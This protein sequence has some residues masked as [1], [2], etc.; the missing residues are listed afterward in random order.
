MFRESRA[1]DGSLSYLSILDGVKLIE[2]MDVYDVEFNRMMKIKEV[3][4]SHDQEVTL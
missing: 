1:H 3:L 4:I 2:D